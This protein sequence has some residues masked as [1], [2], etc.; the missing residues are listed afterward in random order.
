MT[1]ILLIRHAEREYRDDR[2]DS[3]QVL[4]AK[5]QL[6]AQ[7]LGQ[8]LALRLQ[9]EGRK[10]S[11]ILT[12]PYARALQTAELVA[13]PL[14]LSPSQIQSFEPLRP[15]PEGS[16]DGSLERVLTAAPDDVAVVGHGPDLAELSH[17]LCGLPIE[18]KKA[19]AL[20]IEYDTS[21]KTGRF[22]W[23]ISHK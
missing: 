19:H 6:T 22:L 20:A 2:Q 14:G 12:S 1:L 13:L 8:K 21:T 7:K 4:T 16:V 3:Q 15:E 17:R 11:L 23:Q 10:I 9:A 5:G 18:L